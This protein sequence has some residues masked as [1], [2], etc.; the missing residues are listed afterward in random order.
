MTIEKWLI[1]HGERL[2]GI[3]TDA[4]RALEFGIQIVE[5]ERNVRFVAPNGVKLNETALATMLEL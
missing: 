1:L 4:R 5:S 2:I 3:E